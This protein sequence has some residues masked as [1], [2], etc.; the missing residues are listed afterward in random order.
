MFPMW[1]CDVGVVEFAYFRLRVCLCLE[2]WSVLV[3]N[4]PTLDLRITSLESSI[5]VSE[6]SVQE[7]NPPKKMVLLVLILD[8]EILLSY[9]VRANYKKYSYETHIKLLSFKK[10]IEFRRFIMPSSTPS[11]ELFSYLY[12][13]LRPPP[14]NKP[15]PRQKKTTVL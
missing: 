8:N 15:I 5:P 13:P 6:F 11:P 12:P 14:K 2:P 1:V 7:V 4:V 9:D 3:H 10:D